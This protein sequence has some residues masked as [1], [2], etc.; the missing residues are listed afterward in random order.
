MR[1]PRLS[2]AALVLICCVLGACGSD[3][4]AASATGSSIAPASSDSAGADATQPASPSGS[5]DCAAVKTNLAGLILNWQVVIGLSNSP[6][7]EW[8]TTPI[9]SITK[10]GDQ[11]AAITAGLGSDPDAATAL[12]FMS[13]AN[14]IVARGIGGDSAAQAD[15][16]T[17][18]GTDGGANIVKQLAIS[19]A[20]QKVCK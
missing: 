12:T 4:P 20:Y 6:A 19:T 18:M 13:G 7:S 1:L 10:F 14:D 16:A 2:F 8:A 3:K 17:Y 15:L 11:V 9:G 5:I